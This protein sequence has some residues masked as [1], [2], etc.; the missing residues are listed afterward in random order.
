MR[1]LR[2]REI[3]RVS[4]N[5]KAWTVARL[6]FSVS[7]ICFAVVSNLI[8]GDPESPWMVVVMGAAIVLLLVTV[9]IW[10]FKR[11]PS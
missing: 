5:G 3:R 2:D 9:T 7:V 8:W 4:Y 1:P 10:Y 11:G 6:V